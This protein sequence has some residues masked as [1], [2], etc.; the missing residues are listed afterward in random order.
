MNLGSINSLTALSPQLSFL[1]DTIT[2]VLNQQT[3][4]AVDLVEA[5]AIV[6]LGMTTDDL[7][8]L[9]DPMTQL[10]AGYVSGIVNPQSGLI[11]DPLEASVYSTLGLTSSQLSSYAD[12]LTQLNAGLIGGLLNTI[13]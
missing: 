6:N 4:F 11:S 2:G 8:S 3:G 7:V 13:A 1:T 12:P 5:S 9:A 10:E